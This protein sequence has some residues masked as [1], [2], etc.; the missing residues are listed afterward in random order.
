MADVRAQKLAQSALTRLA[1]EL[2][3]GRCRNFDA[4]GPNIGTSTVSHFRNGS[5]NG[6]RNR[7]RIEQQCGASG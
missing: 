2:Q 7:Y 3:A 5:A 1:A 6:N 4:P